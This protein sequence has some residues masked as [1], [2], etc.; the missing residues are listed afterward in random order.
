MWLWGAAAGG[1]IFGRLGDRHGRVRSLMLAVLTYS[2]FTGLSA[3]SQHWWHLAACRFLGALGLGGAWPL[4][5]AILVE[6]W[7]ERHR[8]VLAGCMGA[9]ANVGFLIAATYSGIL[10]AAGYDWRWV[11]GVGAAIGLSGLL[12]V[13]FVPE[14]T[15]W[16]E[17]RRECRK[18]SLG[19]L[20]TPRYRRS[21]IVGSLLST[22]GLLGTWGSFLWLA[23]YVDKVSEGT[24]FEGRAGPAISQWQAYGQIV[25]GFLG[26]ILAKKLG[27][28]LS[29][30]LLCIC[31]WASVVALYGLNDAFGAQMIAMAVPAGIF[32]TAFF[33]WLPKFLTELYPTRIRATGQGFSFNI[34]RI[35][36]G[37]GVLSAGGLVAL[38]DGRY[39]KG[40]MVMASV[41]LLGL[42]VIAFAPDTGGKM[43][44]DEEDAKSAGEK[45]A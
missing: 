42:L 45:A 13:A 12:L 28:K 10:R 38:F 17:A 11:I 7:P 26:G 35:L 2:C 3:F 9:G 39:E 34:G 31:A 23:T 20:F 16:K 4:S 43:V 6:T 32:V 24:P 36:A 19:D 41:Y 15:R 40:M 44:S 29:W 21:T 5:V 30:V 25:G 22:V 18:S 1:I 8:S 27:N 37:I 33:G 14:T